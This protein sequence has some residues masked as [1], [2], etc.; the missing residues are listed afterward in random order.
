M[1]L[2][3]TVRGWQGSAWQLDGICLPTSLP[4][5]LPPPVLSGLFHYQSILCTPGNGALIAL[6]ELNMQGLNYLSASE[7]KRAKS[8]SDVE[9]L[10]EEMQKGMQRLHGW[11]RGAAWSEPH[12]C[13]SHLLGLFLPRWFMYW[14]VGSAQVWVLIQRLCCETAQEPPLCLKPTTATASPEKA[15]KNAQTNV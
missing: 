9:Q 14:R 8:P 2:H 4:S 12:M 3:C 7:Q 5:S 6:Q 13:T 15:K 1:S 11:A 10:L